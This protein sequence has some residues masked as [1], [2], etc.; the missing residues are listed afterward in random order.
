GRPVGLVLDVVELADR[1]HAGLPELAEGD[2][3]DGDDRLRRERR[4]R[5]VHLAAPGP[6]VV[7][8]VGAAP[9]RLAA[10]PA[11]EGVRV[12]GGECGEGERRWRG[13][14]EEHAAWDRILALLFSG[15]RG[16]FHY[17]G[18]RG[19]VAF[20]APFVAA[21]PPATTNPADAQ[22]PPQT[23]EQEADSHFKRG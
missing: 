19:R 14:V 23:Q 2:A 7:P 10:H 3:A 6:E 12:R 5:A 9:L 20:A 13:G 22:P 11:L 18:G 17:A 21:L 8:R 4:R 15:G 16:D 1:A